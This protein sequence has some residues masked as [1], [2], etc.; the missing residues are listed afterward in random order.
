MKESEYVSKFLK[1]CNFA[2][3]LVEL[4]QSEI[5]FEDHVELMQSL[6]QG[7]YDPYSESPKNMKYD[8]FFVIPN[9]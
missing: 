1:K 8:E 7:A 2:E 5:T 6:D 3:F 9:E 4:N